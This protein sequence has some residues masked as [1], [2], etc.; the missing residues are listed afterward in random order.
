V[1]RTALFAALA[2]A[3]GCERLVTLATTERADWSYVDTA[4]GGATLK[5]ASLTDGKLT[6]TPRLM[7]HRPTRLDSA[8]CIAG[9]HARQD[10]QRLLFWFDKALCSNGAARLPYAATMPGPPAGTYEV[11]YDDA[12]AGFP[13]LGR[14]ALDASG[15]R[16]LA[17]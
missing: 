16:V 5:S 15:A 13:R 7:L 2:I 9:V 8:I 10:G 14:I 1:K 17:P 3:T 11:V 4:W 6:L 12:A